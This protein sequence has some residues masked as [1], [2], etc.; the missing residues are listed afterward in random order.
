MGSSS[1]SL[2]NNQSLLASIQYAPFISVN[3][4]LSSYLKHLGKPRSA[5]CESTCLRLYCHIVVTGW[6]GSTASNARK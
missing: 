6:N 4:M 3:G 1:S 2:N 5:L